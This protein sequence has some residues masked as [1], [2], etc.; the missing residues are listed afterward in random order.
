MNISPFFLLSC[1]QEVRFSRV[2]VIGSMAE[3]DRRPALMIRI[4]DIQNNLYIAEPHVRLHMATSKINKVNWNLINFNRKYM[5]N[6][7]FD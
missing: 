4:A 2:A 1:F 3:T 6:I 5:I 7:N